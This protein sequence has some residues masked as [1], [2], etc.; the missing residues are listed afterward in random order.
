MDYLRA[1][2]S[3]LLKNRV[4]KKICIRGFARHSRK[5]L[6]RVEKEVEI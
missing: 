1:F 4:S 2:Y 5:T 6:A 3:P